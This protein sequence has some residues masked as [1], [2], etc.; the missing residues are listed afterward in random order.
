MESLNLVLIPALLL[1]TYSFIYSVNEYL[2]CVRLGPVTRG[3]IV[4]GTLEKE[5]L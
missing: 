5:V 4:Q 1:P 2:L 3:K